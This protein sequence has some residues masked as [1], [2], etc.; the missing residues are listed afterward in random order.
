MRIL[1]MGTPDIAAA[2]LGALLDAGM[3][4]VGAVTREDK[5]K[6]RGNVMTPPPVKILAQAHGV[7]VYQP[8]TVRDEAFLE[9]LRQLA[10]DV[11][12]V[13]AYGKILPPAVLTCP[14]LGCINVHVSLLPK[15]RGAAPMQRAIMAGEHET[16]VTLMYM[17]E[18][19]DTGDIIEARAFPIAP[20]DTLEEVH[21]RSAALGAEMLTAAMQ[22]LAAG[23]TLPR[24]P[25]PQTGAS[26]ALRIEK[27]E[28]HID[29]TRPAAVLDPF[30]RGITPVPMAY[31]FLNGAKLKLTPAVPVGGHGAPGEVIDLCDSGAGHF[32]VA[33]GEGALK[34]TALIPEG[35]G[36]MTAGDF[37]RGRKIKKGDILS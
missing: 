25:Q 2:S 11:I 29:F 33:C 12:A 24:H 8:R 30:I 14:P 3:N 37:I 27:E 34:F 5:P 4:V 17:D 26:V 10:P 32:T 18:G 13:V 22:T 23:G 21:D 28:C 15:Y 36:K 16:G 19:M 20:T 9:L 31:A 1:F 7:P 6:G 35:K